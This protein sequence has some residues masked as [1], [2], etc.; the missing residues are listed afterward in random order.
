MYHNGKEELG[1]W[2]TGPGR[3]DPSEEEWMTKAK[4][5]PKLL[6]V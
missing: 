4:A 2:R 1:V 3:P 5:N 6:T